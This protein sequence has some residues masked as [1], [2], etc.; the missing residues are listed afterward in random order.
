MKT[1]TFLRATKAVKTI[2]GMRAFKPASH[3]IYENHRGIASHRGVENQFPNASHTHLTSA[4]HVGVE[5]HE[6]LLKRIK[7]EKK[8]FK[9]HFFYFFVFLKKCFELK[10]KRFKQFYIAL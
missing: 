9:N 3:F 2:R 8:R 4:S 5:N 6:N 10:K 1:N 7:R